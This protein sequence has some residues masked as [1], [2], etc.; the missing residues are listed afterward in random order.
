[1]NDDHSNESAADELP[2][3]YEHKQQGWIHIPMEVIAILML[4]VIW[5]P[6]VPFQVMLG[7]TIGAG[8]L[9]LLTLMFRTLTIKDEGENLLAQF[10]PWPVFRKR[11]PYERIVSAEAGKTSLIDGLGYHWIPMR[12]WTLNIAGRDCVH[13]QMLSGSSIRLGTDDVQGLLEVVNRKL[14]PHRRDV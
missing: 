1:M 14:S 5:L 3:P 9:V 12:G 10:G 7:L 4:L 11:I 8:I 6:D 13:L 2:A